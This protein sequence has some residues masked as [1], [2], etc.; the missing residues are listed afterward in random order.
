[1]RASGRFLLALPVLPALA[2]LALSI[3]RFRADDSFGGLASCLGGMLLMVLA[4]VRL[5]ASDRGP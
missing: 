1:M 4:A 5:P 3:W 2:G